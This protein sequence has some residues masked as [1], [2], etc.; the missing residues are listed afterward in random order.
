MRNYRTG[1]TAR[2]ARRPTPNDG[3]AQGNERHSVHRIK[4]LPVADAVEGFSAGIDSARLFL[5]VAQ[6]G[7]VEHD[8]PTSG[9][10]RARD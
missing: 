8:Q 3:F 7:P 10:E 4:R 6:H 5:C 2:Q 1:I 9:D